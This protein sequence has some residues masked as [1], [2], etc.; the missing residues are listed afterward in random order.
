MKTIARHFIGK[1]LNEKTVITLVANFFLEMN[2]VESNSCKYQINFKDGDLLH[3]M[4][5]IS[6]G[7]VGARA[8]MDFSVLIRKPNESYTKIGASL[9]WASTD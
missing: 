7:S 3:Y 6:V 1:T 9:L 2:M 8:P 4:G 5:V